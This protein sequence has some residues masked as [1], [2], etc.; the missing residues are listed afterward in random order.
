MEEEIHDEWMSA[1]NKLRLTKK[2]NNVLEL[3]KLENGAI[4][5]QQVIIIEPEDEMDL[6][7]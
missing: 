5:E 4:R 1:Q 6:R 2:A 3:T 7:F